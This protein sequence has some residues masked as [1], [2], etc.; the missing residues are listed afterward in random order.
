MSMRMSVRMSV[1]MSIHISMHM[2]GPMSICMAAHFSVHMPT[3]FFSIC[4]AAHFFFL[5]RSIPMTI[6]KHAEYFL[7]SK[8]ARADAMTGYNGT[9]MAQQCHLSGTVLAP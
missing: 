1:Y 8:E 5:H 3:A 9:R 4:M 2:S 6:H 7:E